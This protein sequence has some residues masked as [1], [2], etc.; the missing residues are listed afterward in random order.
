[1]S[2]PVPSQAGI[3]IDP[4]G[5][6]H[7]QYTVCSVGMDKLDPWLVLVLDRARERRPAVFD[8]RTIHA[9]MKEIRNLPLPDVHAPD[10]A[11]S[12]MYLRWRR[13]MIQGVLQAHYWPQPSG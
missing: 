2:L 9:S 12:A 6:L 1:M 8:L 3:E 13:L 11:V 4:F 7:G 5:A 10:G